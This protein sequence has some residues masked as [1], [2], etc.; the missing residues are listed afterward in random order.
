MLVALNNDE[1]NSYQ[2][3]VQTNFG[4]NVQLHEYTGKHS[5]IWTDGQGRATFTVPRNVNGQSYLCFSRTG[6][7]QPFA[8]NQRQTTQTFFGASD[9]DVGPVN[10]G[11]AVTPGR[12]WC[13]QGSAIHA[14]LAPT[15]LKWGAG[16]AIALEVLDDKGAV[17]ASARQASPTVPAS[18]TANATKSGWFQ[19]SLRGSGL[20]SPSPYELSVTYTGTQELVL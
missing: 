16:A 13:Q 3:T 11:T 14:T 20:P 1:W 9:L 18:V 5:D 2:R 8:L 19:L 15:S 4:S 17:L 7:G 6:V 10:N 12:I